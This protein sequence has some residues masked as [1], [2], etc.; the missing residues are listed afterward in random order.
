MGGAMA[1]VVG[2]IVSSAWQLL[3]PM[4]W[5]PLAGMLFVGALVAGASEVAGPV[6][7]L[8]AAAG[9]GALTAADR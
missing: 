1:A 6:T 2:L 7:V 3:R 5:S 9:L 4:G 8:L